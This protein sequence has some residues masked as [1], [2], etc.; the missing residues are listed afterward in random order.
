M[1]LTTRILGPS[2]LVQSVVGELLEKTPQSYFDRTMEIVQ[3]SFLQPTT[4]K[5]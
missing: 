3:V 5:T 2:S 1:D 4:T